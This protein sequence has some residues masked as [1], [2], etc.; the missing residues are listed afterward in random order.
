MRLKKKY[1]ALRLFQSG[2]G[3]EIIYSI[4]ARLNDINSLR[5]EFL[6]GS[7]C[8]LGCDPKIKI[9]LNRLCATDEREEE[10]NNN[11]GVAF[12]RRRFLHF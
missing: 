8:T 9:L 2:S 10:R 6:L 12:I 5:F 1:D 11:V 3:E 7:G 4:S